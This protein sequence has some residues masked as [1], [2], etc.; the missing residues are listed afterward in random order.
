MSIV[1]QRDPRSGITYVYESY[2]YW[3]KTEKKHKAKRKCI[4][5]LDSEGNVVATRGRRGRPPKETNES[6]S[7]EPK[8]EAEKANYVR[9]LK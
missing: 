4:G 8:V 1:R 6:P 2:N 5:K 3:D 9:S 7:V